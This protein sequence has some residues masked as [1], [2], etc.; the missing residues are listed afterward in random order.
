M[1]GSLS[2]MA[3]EIV[4]TALAPS[5]CSACDA[6]V[7]LLAAFC[8]TCAATVERSAWATSGAA[9][10]YGGAIARAITRMKYEKR[11]DLGRPLGHLLARS[12]EPHALV[13]GRSGRQPRASPS[14]DAVVVPVPLH[15]ARLAT[16]GFNQASLVADHVAKRLG[17]RF[18]PLALGRA[19]D[20]PHQVAL[21]RSARLENMTGAF[22]VRNPAVVRGRRILLVD[23]VRT[24]G[25][26]LE[27]C[28]HV[29]RGAGAAHVATAAVACAER[30]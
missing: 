14:Q 20:T 3:L 2:A 5:R 18:W 13:F 12:L 25:A 6:P 26:T 21:D 19:R 11:P 29:L 15:P 30:P 1:N 27:A 8:R 7:A 16:R 28:A 22:F 23:D 10:V 17:A 9:F 24:T 4:A